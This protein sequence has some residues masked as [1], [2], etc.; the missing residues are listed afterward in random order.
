M[1][2]RKTV[3]RPKN[4]YVIGVAQSEPGVGATHF[5]IAFA[6]YLTHVEK[7][8]TAVVSFAGKGAYRDMEL[9]CLGTEKGGYTLAEID[10]YYGYNSG[11]LAEELY[12]RD[13]SIMIIDFSRELGEAYQ[14]FLRSDC[15]MVIGSLEM[16]RE[17]AYDRFLQQLKDMSSIHSYLAPFASKAQ[18]KRMQRKYGIDVEPI[19]F[20]PDVFLL[21]RENLVFYEQLFR[22]M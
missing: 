2:R 12:P 1:L 5:V 7:K 10:F 13:Y 22:R 19:P 18:R 11:R 9:R 20:E 4:R 6:N 14:D 16:W 17:A 21:R 3:E 8:K 15:R